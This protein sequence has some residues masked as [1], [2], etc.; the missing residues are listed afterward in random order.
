M[1][2]LRIGSYIDTLELE[3]DALREQVKALKH[4]ISILEGKRLLVK[5]DFQCLK[6]YLKLEDFSLVEL[7]H[8]SFY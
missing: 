2:G 3:N 4:R 5:K 7:I 1:S 8:Y 6:W